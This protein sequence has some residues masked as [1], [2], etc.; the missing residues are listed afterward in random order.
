LEKKRRDPMVIGEKMER[1]A[2]QRRNRAER[3]R[4]WRRVQQNRIH[5]GREN[6]RR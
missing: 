4:K 5:T 2:F 1:K 3:L 6:D